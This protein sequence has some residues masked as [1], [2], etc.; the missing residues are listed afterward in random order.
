MTII[1]IIVIAIL[2][3]L[4]IQQYRVRKRIIKTSSRLIGEQLYEIRALTV[5][6][7][8]VDANYKALEEGQQEIV[9]NYENDFLDLKEKA[10]AAQN[11]AKYDREMREEVEKKLEQANLLIEKH[12][13]KCDILV[14][15]IADMLISE[16]MPKGE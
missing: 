10:E 11:A 6:R 4:L 3:G 7:D 5:Q 12:S 1:L 9:D 14:E 13:E 16:I 2:L 15:D 8:A